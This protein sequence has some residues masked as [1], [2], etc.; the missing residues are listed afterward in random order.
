APVAPGATTAGA[1]PGGRGGRE[2]GI[3]RGGRGGEGGRFGG[4][5]QRFQTLGVEQ[6][7]ASAADAAVLDATPA[8]RAS[9]DP[10]ASLLPAGFSIDSPLESVAVSGSMVAVDR[11]LMSD[12]LQA[13]GRGEFGL[14]EGQQFA[15]A[16]ALTGAFAD[17]QAGIGGGAAGAGG[18]G[19]RGGLGGRG[20]G[21]SGLQVSANYG[22][23]G[24]DLDASPYSLR[25]EAPAKRD[26]LQQTFATTV[27]GAL[28]IPHLYDGTN[29]TTFNFSYTGS[30]SGD[31]FDQYATVPSA[32]FRAGDF[33]ASPVAI[34][35]PSTG[36]PFPGNQIPASR[37]SPVAASLLKYIPAATLSGSTQNFRN[38][39]TQQSNSDGFSLRIT[40]SITKPPV[41]TG[42]GGR[43]GAGAAAGGRGG[44]ATATTAAVAAGQPRGGQGATPTA[45]AGGAQPTA[46]AA[47]TQATAAGGR[48]GGGPGGRGG[49]GN[50]APQLN[51]TMTAAINYRHN[52]GDRLN[53]FPDLS[54]NTDGTTLSAPVTINMR[55]G[56]SMH[57]VTFTFN[58]TAST[59]LNNFAFNQ[60]LTGLA[61]ITGVAT[62]PF[63]WGLPTLSFGSY[64]SLRDITP[65]RRT[66]RSLQMGYTWTRSFGAHNYRLGGSFQQ[67]FNDSQSDANARGTYTFSG[68]YTSGGLQT[69]RGTGQD[70][71]DFLL[72]LP[73]QATRQYSLS[74]EN[75]SAPVAIRG[76]NFS[77]FMAD[78]W[79]WKARWTINYGLQ[80][81]YYAPFTEAH[82]RMVNLDV[83]PNFSAVAPVCGVDAG[84]PAGEDGVG[85]FTGAFPAG[86]VN[87]D[88]NNVAPRVGLAWRANNRSVI[89]FGYGLTY[90][91]GAY[92]AIARQLYQQPPFFQTGTVTG[93]LDDPIALADPFAT[94]VAST[95]T[96]NY[97]IDKNYQ[98]GLI[99]QWDVDYS[100]DLLRSWNAGA[101]Y[102]GTRGG[103]LDILRAPNRGPTGL[104]IAGV[105]PFT[106]QSSEG[107]SYMNGVSLRLQKRQTRGISGNMSYTLSKARDN[108]TATGGNATLAQ[109]DQNLDAEWA[110]SN[111]DRRHQ[112]AGS[113]AAQLPW[114][115]NRLWLNQ[116]GWLA[117]LVGDWSMS[118]NVTWQS[119]QPLTA[120]CSTCAANLAQ[121]V[122]GTLRADYTGQ[123]VSLSNPSI[124]EFFNIAAFGIPSAGTFGNSSRNLIV[125]PGSHQVNAQFTRDVALGG[126]RNVSINVVANN[127]L[128][129]VNFGAI[130][131]NVNSPTF[132]QVLSVRGLRTVRVNLRFRF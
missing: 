70:F 19:G 79:R 126:N 131:T 92:S 11:N 86:L 50:V 72:G 25:G 90:N 120:R 106:W 115:K 110:L 24:S 47:G 85:P 35:D 116:G 95:V 34:I 65:S 123:A 1:T 62:D 27:G 44:V 26:Y 69:V 96:N 63:D 36:L 13:L 75:I 77:L 101:T 22:V 52:D 105:E 4:G 108:T 56:R 71:A 93:T 74:P 81:D 80:Y 31:L 99:H 118:T 39:G 114:G 14:A 111:F 42:R 89:R 16:G 122:S 61:G 119:G 104:R 18:G 54:G 23:G 12:R 82:G 129:A 64:T 103:S 41:N 53:V 5:P 51:V 127:L 6:S 46:G 43:G 3:G 58:R 9:E 48:Q 30:R 55:Y 7:N 102:I 107:S 59:T 15:A 40:H 128:N 17:A 97:G 45:P 84:C 66:D 125:G 21:G 67:Q 91:T 2:G 29:R 100:R 121:G 8:T 76:H 57:S 124:D 94:I 60:D 87:P 68:L 33:S 112:L 28:K 10:A 78:D 113:L 88:W 49:R 117:S 38:T 98:L 130:D 132:G 32:A 73:Q 37:I 83:A 109:D 20:G